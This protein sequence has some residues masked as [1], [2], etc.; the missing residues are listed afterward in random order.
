MQQLALFET[1]RLPRKPYCSDDLSHGLKIRPLKTALMMRYIQH[2]RPGMASYIAF[3]IDRADAGIAW[4]DSKAPRPT[5][6]IKNPENGHAHYLYALSTPVC[7]SDAARMG[8]LRYLAAVERAIAQELGADPGYS[9][10][11]IKNPAHCYWQTIEVEQAPYSLER[12]ANGLD[13][14]IAA[15]KPRTQ[16][17]TSGLE[18]NCTV[19]EELRHW[20][21]RDVSG[22]WRPDGEDGW[23]RAVRDQAHSLNL[24]RE[25]L[26]Q[27]EVDQIAKSV[28][29]WVW[30]RFSPAARRDLIERTHTPELQA[31]RGAKKGAAKRQECMDKAMLMTLAGHSTRDIAAELGVTAMTVSNWI[32]RSK[33]GK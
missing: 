28:G 15:N 24:F 32:K 18:R 8:P 9:G 33:S 21:Y 17:D 25:P 13:L 31:K 3:D 19:F 30:K 6:I 23:L 14:S 16:V 11:I 22:Y 26:Q 4:I 1:S 29:R 7:T 27:K 10:L 5:Y 12:L 20:A 2:N